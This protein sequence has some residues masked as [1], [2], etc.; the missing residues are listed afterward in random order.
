M[1]IQISWTVAGDPLADKVNWYVTRC[2]VKGKVRKYRLL[3]YNVM[4]HDVSIFN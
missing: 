4:L 3:L 2:T 1:R